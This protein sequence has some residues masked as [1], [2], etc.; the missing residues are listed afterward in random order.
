MLN[1]LPYLHP[2]ALAGSARSRRNSSYDRAGG[3]VD[4]DRIPAGG[5][6]TL[7]DT[8]GPGLVTHLW[9]A[10]AHLDP[11]YLR[12]LVLRAWWNGE[13]EPSLA[14]P[15]GDFFGVGHAVAAKYESLAMN[16]VRGE[17]LRGENTGA[18]CYLPMPFH[19]G[20]R[21]EVANESAVPC[22]ACYYHLDWLETPL[23]T[24]EPYGTFH[25][26]W[27]RQN[28]TGAVPSAVGGLE[29]GRFATTLSDR[30]N[31]P[32][33]SAR[34]TGQFVGMNL[35]IDNLDSEQL[36][37]HINDFGEG[38]EMI[39]LDDEP[40]PPSLHGTG[41]EDYFSDAWGMTGV[42]GHYAGV[43]YARPYLPDGPRQRG[44]CYRFH[45]PDPIFFREALR[46]SFE[47]GHANH[48]ANDLAATAYWY[49]QEP[50]ASFALLPVAARLPVP[51][52]GDPAPE[53]EAAA[54]ELLGTLVD[55]YYDIFI[56]GTREEVRAL[57]AHE[58]AAQTL[59]KAFELR[60]RLVAGEI[61]AAEV[62]AELAP[63]AEA[64]A[65][66]GPPEAKPPA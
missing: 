25:A 2:L 53:E 57:E 28:P 49:Q 62:Q 61:G 10:L 27:T 4:F 51:D 30:D 33:L 50:H 65:E 37:H 18:N 6:L 5:T 52:L 3:N 45:L 58:Q 36:G 64:L 32:V 34:G 1:C 19:R 42:A 13:S 7:L 24:V 41:T 20:A 55:R 9:F 44:T 16:M 60:G 31:F 12:Q 66:L 56:L 17:G 29:F 40:W 43:S 11:N 21:V 14:C 23:A 48:Q 26:S 47:H 15:L 8:D 22:M 35:S 46:F 63:Y 59:G 54:V 38:D 39:F